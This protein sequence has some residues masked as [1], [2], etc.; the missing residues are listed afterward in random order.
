MHL[1]L[2]V[3]I[4]MQ[5]TINI[6]LGQHHSG[7]Q[8][9]KTVKV[10]GTESEAHAGTIGWIP[11]PL[12]FYDFCSFQK[13]NFTQMYHVALESR[14]ISINDNIQIK[15]HLIYTLTQASIQEHEALIYCNLEWPGCTSGSSIPWP[16]YMIGNVWSCLLGKGM[17]ITD[18]T[19]VRHSHK[20]KVLHKT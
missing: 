9:K 5:K 2:A 14:H 18:A 19:H 16:L 3:Y 1:Y 10:S 13:G 6:N 20:T 15:F 7:R 12:T 8:R 17:R 4:K 11:F